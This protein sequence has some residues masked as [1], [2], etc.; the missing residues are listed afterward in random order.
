MRAWR[1]ILCPVDFSDEAR[2]VAL[3]A[4]EL[5]WAFGGEVT[6]LHVWEAPAPTSADA[7]VAAPTLF[8]GIAP[9]LR[10]RIT[11]WAKELGENVK[12]AVVPG[13]PAEDIVRYAREGDFDVI[14][15]GTHGRTGMRHALLGSVAEKV[16]RH[17]E[18]PVVV[19]RKP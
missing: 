14:V 9:E 12:T 6:L 3:H 18:S 15:M 11:G 19:I 8:E 16:I 10:N 5:G 7:F 1:K 4:V 13:S 2:R 17:A